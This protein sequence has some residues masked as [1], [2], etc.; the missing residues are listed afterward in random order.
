MAEYIF[1]KMNI[2]GQDIK[3]NTV[4]A[5]QGFDSTLQI[6]RYR[7]LVEAR[8]EATT[9]HYSGARVYT[10]I[11]FRKRIDVASVDIQKAISS[12]APA[13]VSVDF[14]FFKEN[15]GDGTTL[16]F[17]TVKAKNGRIASIERV[18]EST[19][20]TDGHSSAIPYEIIKITFENIEWSSN[21]GSQKAH[22]DEWVKKA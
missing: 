13:K 18:V 14:H 16:N 19:H 6:D 22:A 5:P 21:L 9:G 4:S 12:P 15:D 2:N 8:L 20:D 10:P 1:A 17:F 7:E 3:G 11:S